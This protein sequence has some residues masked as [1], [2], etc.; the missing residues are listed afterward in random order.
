MVL[1]HE[2]PYL[3]EILVFLAVAG[4]VVPLVR[5]LGI[6]PVLGFLVAGLVV[7][8]HG[9]GRLAGEWP[10]LRTILITDTEGVAVIAEWGVVFLLF[11]IGLEL[12]IPRLWS[13]RRLVF[14]LGSAQVLVSAAAIGAIAWAFGNGTIAATI[15]GLALA[16]SST[17]IVV[18]LLIE[19]MRL[20]A[21]VG[22][23][24]FGILLFQ[25]LAV[26]PILF[27]VTVLGAAT[28][29]PLPLS[30]AI[31]IGQAAAVIAAILVVGRLI[32]RPV[33]RFV[34]GPENRE[35]FMAAA[36][37]AIVGTAVITSLA[38]LSLALGAFLAG[39]LFADTEYRHQINSDIEPFKGLLLGLFFLSVGMTLDLGAVFGQLQWVL[40]SVAGLL[41]LKAAIVLGLALLFRTRFPVA[42][43]S[44][45]LLA[46]GGEFAFVIT[47][48]ALALGLLDPAFT[49]FLLSVVV[50]TMFLTPP[51]AAGARRLGAWLEGRRM[52]E[53]EKEAGDFEASDHVVIAGFGRVG[54]MLARLLDQQ[55]I[56]YLAVDRDPDRVARFR[57]AGAPVHYG[58]AGD[59]HVLA[60]FNLER[61]RAFVSTMDEADCAEH[62]VAAVR[63]RW[64][65][66]PVFARARDPEHGAKLRD[67]GAREVI[68]ETTEA[69]LQL[70]ESLLG[71]LGFPDEAARQTISDLRAASLCYRE[72]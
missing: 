34:G 50:T 66:L 69:S 19:K 32:V 33:F 63:R 29:E 44:A 24:S 14:G 26:V 13:M 38:G 61:A 25:D 55:R 31:A 42:L 62:A 35:F 58:D 4:L 28:A 9:L 17:A 8:P 3:R 5:R 71:G 64:P 70:G 39:L 40:L 43:E 72:D 2:L 51:I 7:G 11:T 46:Q 52:E 16:L 59:E 67:L 23:T 41:V 47:G 30:F 57:E 22:R 18:Q 37:L 48:A 54:E 10:V 49:Q 68:P 20:S 65:D 12:S 60:Q 45:L 1:P 36:L 15:A 56:P 27:L 53:E 21:P 6:S